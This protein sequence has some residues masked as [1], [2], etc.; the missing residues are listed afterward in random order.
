MG[1]QRTR[2]V[3]KGGY[4]DSASTLVVEQADLCGLRWQAD[5]PLSSIRFQIPSFTRDCLGDWAKMDS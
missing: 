1:Q 5:P 3:S 2:L 4:I